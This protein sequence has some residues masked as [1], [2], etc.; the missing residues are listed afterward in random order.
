MMRTANFS[1]W[2]ANVV[3]SIHYANNQAMTNAY[4]RFRNTNLKKENYQFKTE[5]R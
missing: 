1:D 2:M 3:K 5:K 4:S